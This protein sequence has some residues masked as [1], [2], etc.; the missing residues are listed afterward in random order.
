MA[1]EDILIDLKKNLKELEYL[2]NK[3]RFFLGEYYE[4]DDAGWP[5]DNVRYFPRNQ[6][7]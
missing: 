1:S 6:K 3:L 5:Q 4:L 2:Q 7:K